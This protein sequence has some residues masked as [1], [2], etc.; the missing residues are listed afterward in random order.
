MKTQSVTFFL[1]VACLPVLLSQL[2]YGDGE[3]FP[4]A[5]LE[6]FKIWL[7]RI[8][9]NSQN[10]RLDVF[11]HEGGAFKIETRD[12]KEMM[13]APGEAEIYG[14][15]PLPQ[16]ADNPVSFYHSLFQE[17]LQ[18]LKHG[19][20]I[21]DALIAVDYETEYLRLYRPALLEKG[22]CEL[23][24][25]I[26]VVFEPSVAADTK[27]N[28]LNK[29]S[30]STRP[31][32][33]FEVSA[34]M[35]K[36]AAPD[37]PVSGHKTPQYAVSQSM[38]GRHIKMY[39]GSKVQGAIS[40]TTLPPSID[41]NYNLILAPTIARGT[42][43]TT[44][45]KYR[46]GWRDVFR[47]S[48]SSVFGISKVGKKSRVEK[49]EEK[50][51]EDL[52]DLNDKV[53]L[54][55]YQSLLMYDTPERLDRRMKNLQNARTLQGLSD[56]KAPVY[57]ADEGFIEKSFQ[58][59]L[60]S[61]W[62]YLPQRLHDVNSRKEASYYVPIEAATP[63]LTSPLVFRTIRNTAFY[64]DI[65]NISDKVLTII[66]GDTGTGKSTL[67]T[68]YT[69]SLLYL[70]EHE[71][72]NTG[73]VSLDVGGSNSWLKDE[74]G[75]LSFD[76]ADRGDDGD[77]LPC[78]LHPLHCILDPEKT[79]HS[80]Q[81]MG[82]AKQFLSK[83]MKFKTHE[84]IAEQAIEKALKSTIAEQSDYRFS[85]FLKHFE[86]QFKVFEAEKKLSDAMRY[87]WIEAIAIMKNYSRGGVFGK[88]YDPDITTRRNLD[89]V[90]KFYSN[91]DLDQVQ[92]K[93]LVS[94]HL[95]LGYLI[96]YSLCLKYSATSGQYRLMH[97]HVDEF[98]Q[99]A[100]FIDEAE[101][102]ELKNQARKIGFLVLLGIQSPKHLLLEK[103]DPEKRKEIFQGIRE[104]W[105]GQVDFNEDMTKFATILEMQAPPVG[106]KLSGKLLELQK[107]VEFN[108]KVYKLRESARGVTDLTEAQREAVEQYS[109]CYIGIARDVVNL[110][111]DVEI[112]WQWEVTTRAAGREVRGLV[113]KEFHL[114]KR[115]AAKILSKALPKVPSTKLS[116]HELS[117]LLEQ[118]K[119]E[120]FQ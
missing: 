73:L 101:L 58:A 76:L 1:V 6:R 104:M 14:L 107:A 112:E 24:R 91:V 20:M 57:R 87:E 13:I 95:Q 68:L 114:S 72:I 113:M 9:F 46:E 88:I 17:A 31:L 93:S 50:D 74:D 11:E 28:V 79:Q 56:D 89:G 26:F 35:E 55:L 77:P 33:P 2:A 3:P 59:A 32:L 67:L 37:S 48:M 81:E 83:V 92:V 115:E 51:Q 90:T 97:F 82:L 64:V 70:E 38:N 71:G 29:L 119:R 23:Q 62:A 65:Q 120:N 41:E 108:K 25:Y 94:F 40:L 96:G 36:V 85:I 5:A 86:D 4:D 63:A 98:K 12:E 39:P 75:V 45:F 44:T 47:R 116:N 22:I 102:L 21:K 10:R 69:K 109:I 8:M 118:I 18:T 15:R 43:I 30:T 117:K 42:V 105:V 27:E 54:Q 34:Y 49:A 7:R 80:A 66:V 16:A 106:Q 53:E 78:A 60:P 99:Q 52:E 19:C 103:I 110:F 61:A 111:V 84:Q 100:A